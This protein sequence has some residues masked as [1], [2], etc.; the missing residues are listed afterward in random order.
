MKI[1]AA[2]ATQDNQISFP[3]NSRSMLLKEGYLL[4]T[5]AIVTSQGA[6]IPTQN[7]VVNNIESGCR[8]SRQKGQ[9]WKGRS[10]SHGVRTSVRVSVK[11]IASTID[12]TKEAANQI[13]LFLDTRNIAINTRDEARKATSRMV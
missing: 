10:N 6:D 4:N 7:R 12:A 3:L 1:A 13:R 2:I 9:W 5:L 8:N 11:P